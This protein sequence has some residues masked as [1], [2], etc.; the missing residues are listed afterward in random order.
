MPSK[1]STKTQ[2]RFPKYIVSDA[3]RGTQSIGNGLFAKANISSGEFV[4][5]MNKEK[6][7]KYSESKWESYRIAKRMRIPHDGSIFVD[8]IRKRVTDWSARMPIWYRINHSPNPTLELKYEKGRVVWR[9]YRDILVGEE[10]TFNY[11]EN[12][13]GWI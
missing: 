2:K 5:G 4:I 11:R 7:Q 9:A 8:R 6:I 1:I 12:V 3:Y 13:D 10:L